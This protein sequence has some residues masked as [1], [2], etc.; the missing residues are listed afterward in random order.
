MGQSAAEAV[1]KEK[2]TIAFLIE[3]LTEVI[4]NPGNFGLSHFVDELSV[5]TGARKMSILG[6]VLKLKGDSIPN[7]ALKN[8]FD[9]LQEATKEHKG[10]HYAIKVYQIRLALQME[11]TVEAMKKLNTLKKRSSHITEHYMGGT[12]RTVVWNNMIISA[13]EAHCNC[14]LAVGE[15]PAKTRAKSAGEAPP[16]GERPRGSIDETTVTPPQFATEPSK[17]KRVTLLVKSPAQPTPGKPRRGEKRNLTAKEIHDKLMYT[18]RETV[19]KRI[20]TNTLLEG[21]NP[22]LLGLVKMYPL[23]QEDI[24][25]YQQPEGLLALLDLQAQNTSSLYSAAKI[26]HKIISIVIAL[27]QNKVNEAQTQFNAL[28]AEQT[29]MEAGYDKLKASANFL[30][31]NPGKTYVDMLKEMFTA[32]AGIVNDSAVVESTA[33]QPAPL[34]TPEQLATLA[35]LQVALNALDED[36]DEDESDDSDDD[37]DMLDV[38]EASGV[39]PKVSQ[40]TTTTTTTVAES[41][42]PRFW[43][44]PQQPTRL[45]RP[46]S[47]NPEGNDPEAERKALRHQ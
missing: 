37:V 46:A 12:E 27:S 32:L 47:F 4:K 11:Q 18:L 13:L 24:S 39:L 45:K 15:P 38:A 19:K 22:C 3:R 14:A 34:A 36:S 30:S 26:A 41:A 43:T 10:F 25:L 28:Q 44:P 9:Q 33:S 7:Q 2:K 21:T 42:L 17:V 5:G 1:K 8:S 6:G 35:K 23:S 29:S 16:E 40:T 31:A 20:D